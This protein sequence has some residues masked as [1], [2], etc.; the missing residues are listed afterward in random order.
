MFAVRYLTL[1][2]SLKCSTPSLVTIVHLRREG[3]NDSVEAINH[4]GK[5]PGVAAVLLKLMN[6][7]PHLDDRKVT[8]I[9][10]VSFTSTYAHEIAW[11][12]TTQLTESRRFRMLVEGEVVWGCFQRPKQSLKSLG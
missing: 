2:L 3:R 10:E 4:R 6:P 1:L 8:R 12:S 7:L 9:V 5:Y 11:I